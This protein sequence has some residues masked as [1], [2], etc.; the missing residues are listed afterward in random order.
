MKISRR[1]VR[2]LSVGLMG[3]IT[4]GMIVVL[5]LAN[6]TPAMTAFGN[7][8]PSNTSV[9][10][11]LALTTEA[12]N[13]SQVSENSSPILSESKQQ[14][15]ALTPSTS[16]LTLG[17]LSNLFSRIGRAFP[18]S[19]SIGGT[20]RLNTACE[21]IVAATDKHYLGVWKK[22]IGNPEKAKCKEGANGIPG[23]WI[24]RDLCN[25]DTINDGKF[26]N[27]QVLGVNKCKKY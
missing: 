22:V 2:S 5:G 12:N 9:S 10:T 27:G 3:L 14:L 1:V 25:I 13:N 15:S 11:G 24:D 20:I 8:V 16:F 26:F 18:R 6:A 17:F 19:Q 21:G 4:F 7:P 23:K